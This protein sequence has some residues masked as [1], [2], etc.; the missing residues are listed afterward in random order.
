[1]GGNEGS[2]RASKE[3]FW[4]MKTSLS[5]SPGTRVSAALRRNR[6]LTFSI[7]L[8]IAASLLVR[9]AVAER[10][11]TRSHPGPDKTIV[12]IDEPDVSSADVSSASTAYPDIA[13]QEGDRVTVDAGGCVQTG[14]VGK[15]WKRYVDPSGPNSDRL[16]HG[17]IWIP[18]ATQQ[19]V[20]ISTLIGHSVRVHSEIPTNLILYLGYEDDDYHDNGYWGHDDGTDDQCKGS[21]GGPAWVELTITHAFSLVGVWNYTMSSEQGGGVHQGTITLSQSGQRVTGTMTQFDGTGTSVDGSYSNDTL[22]MTRD[23]GL[24]TTQNYTLTRSGNSLS[25]TFRNVG[26][27]PDNGS[28]RMD[29]KNDQ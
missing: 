20:R 14:G 23:T 21:S 1:L 5:H 17:L 3:G 9:T 18:G 10:R 8:L 24:N 4:I 25:G 28:F 12:R 29:W 16:Y 7:G 11:V 26:Q 19:M 13:F 2:V 15:T 6:R 27:F 22:V